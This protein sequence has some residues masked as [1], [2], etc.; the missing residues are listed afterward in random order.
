M[1][2]PAKRYVDRVARFAV[3]VSLSIA[4]VCAHSRLLAAHTGPV[5]RLA[6][7]RHPVTRD[8]ATYEFTEYCLL[9]YMQPTT[10]AAGQP[11]HK[12]VIYISISR[13]VYS[14]LADSLVEIIRVKTVL[15]VVVFF[16][17]G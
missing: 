7:C 6:N 15:L 4:C 8:G 9:H 1:R 11:E 13:N 16:M 5:C 10:P 2:C 17:G 12:Y 14:I 3:Q